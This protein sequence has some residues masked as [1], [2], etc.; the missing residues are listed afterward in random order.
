[1][2]FINLYILYPLQVSLND[3]TWPKSGSSASGKQTIIVIVIFAVIL[4]VILIINA[5]RGKSAGSGSGGGKTVP[6]GFSQGLLSTGW[7]GT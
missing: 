3:M 6:G 5:S 1:M 7:Q 2:T 4:G